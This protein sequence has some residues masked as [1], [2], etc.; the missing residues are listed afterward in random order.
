MFQEIK[1]LKDYLLMLQDEKDLV[2]TCLSNVDLVQEMMD[3]K[4]I[5]AQRAINFLNYQSK[6]QLQF[7]GVQD[8]EELIVHAKKYIVKETLAKEVL[9]KENVLKVRAHQ[10]KHAFKFLFDNGLPSFWNK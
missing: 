7:Y 1:K 5:Q 3:D 10:F 2:D 8:R 9:M 4:P 6:M